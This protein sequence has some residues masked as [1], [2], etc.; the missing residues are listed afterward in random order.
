MHGRV[1]AL[2]LF[3]GRPLL[4]YA[5]AVLA[6]HCERILLSTNH[7][8]HYADL[9]LSCVSDLYPGMGPVAGLHAGLAAAAGAPVLVLP[10]DVPLLEPSDMLP[11]IQAGPGHDVAVYGHERGSEPLI[12][13]Y[14]P[15][16]APVLER[17]LESGR[18][19]AYELLTLA[20][21]CVVPWNGDLRRL[22]N[23]NRLEDLRDLERDPRPHDP[24]S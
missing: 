11:L 12:G 20:R 9:G 3:R 21:S 15:T 2:E 5:R 22:S 10:C 4:S 1:K 23:V 17:M 13:W 7:A 19:P 14:A 6:A 8:E 16:A 18:A 24:A